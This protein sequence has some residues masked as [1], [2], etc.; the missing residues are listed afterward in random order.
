MSG[1]GAPLLKSPRSRAI[2]ISRVRT[3]SLQ[4]I[5]E[6]TRQTEAAAEYDWAT[7]R[8]YNRIIDHRQ[9]HPIKYQHEEEEEEVESA[10]NAK[11]ATSDHDLK[12]SKG[13]SSSSRGSEN[14]HPFPSRY[15]DSKS[16]VMELEEDYGE[17]FELDL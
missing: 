7:W 10:S 11:C 16:M 15:G 5:L 2:K 14:L 1:R 17:V 13:I 4:E 6:E 8:M 9:K 12:R 3:Q